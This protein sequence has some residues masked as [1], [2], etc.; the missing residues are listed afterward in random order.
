MTS[1]MKEG[2]IYLV[3]LDFEYKMWKNHLEWFLRD[4]KIVKDRNEE[5]V[6]MHGPHELNSVEKLVLD[7][8]EQRLNKMLGRIKNRE[9]EMQYYNKDFPVTLNHPYAK[10]HFELRQKMKQ[11]TAEVIGKISDLIEE[12]SI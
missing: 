6:R 3:D 9:Q 5:I 8:Y 12:L 1:A 10:E 4:L 11:I 2:T 7:E